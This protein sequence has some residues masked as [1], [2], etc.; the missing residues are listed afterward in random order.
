MTDDDRPTDAM[1]AAAWEVIY[2]NRASAP[3]VGKALQIDIVRLALTA[4]LATR[5][6]VGGGC[7]TPPGRASG[8]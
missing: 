2:G 8:Q 5:T 3:L 7:N 1:V 4:A 6:S